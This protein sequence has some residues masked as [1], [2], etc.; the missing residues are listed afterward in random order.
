M[1]G[2]IAKSRSKDVDTGR[3]E[4][5]GQFLVSIFCTVSNLPFKLRIRQREPIISK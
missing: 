3:V 2:G 1:M 4:N 5:Y